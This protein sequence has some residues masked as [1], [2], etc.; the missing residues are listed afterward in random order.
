MI[1]IFL[2]SVVV[3][4]TTIGWRRGLTPGAPGAASG[5]AS[6]MAMCQLLPAV[7]SVLPGNEGSCHRGGV[8]VAAVEVPAGLEG[9]DL[10]VDD[11]GTG[12]GHLLEDRLAVGVGA[13]EDGDVV[14]DGFLVVELQRE[15]LAGVGGQ[16]RLVKGDPVG[17]DLAGGGV[18]RAAAGRAPLG[19]GDP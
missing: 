11:P 8:D 12:E 4:H 18:L 10:V 19:I 17:G 3:S 1:P 16:A 13:L 9:R 14:G 7:G 2:W 5:R 15:R 6:V